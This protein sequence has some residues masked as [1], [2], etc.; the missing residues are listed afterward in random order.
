MLT[1]LVVAAVPGC[2]RKEKDEQIAADAK[3]LTADST[4][5]ATQA[6]VDEDWKFHLAWP[7]AG[8]KMMGESDVSRIGPDLVAGAIANNN[9]FGVIV[10]AQADQTIDQYVD[11]VLANRKIGSEAI[12]SRAAVQVAGVEGVRVVYTTQ[13]EQMPYRFAITAVAHEGHWYQLL[14]WSLTKNELLASYDQFVAAFSFL[15]GTPKGRTARAVVQ[16]DVDGPDWRLREGVFESATEG[17]RVRPSHDWRVAVGVELR[18]MNDSADVGLVHANPDVFVVML[19]DVTPEVAR[20]SFAESRRAEISASGGTWA[21]EPWTATLA[22]EPLAFRRLVGQP[23]EYLHAVRFDHTRA[24]QV[25]GWY[26]GNARDKAEPMLVH[27]F[28]G[29]E[30]MTDG[31]RESLRDELVAAVDPHEMVGEHERLREGVFRDYEHGIEW[32]KPEGLWRLAIGDEARASNPDA[33]LTGESRDVG[34]LFEL[35]AQGRGGRDADLVHEEAL[36]TYGLTKGKT[37]SIA[38]ADGTMVLSRAKKEHGGIVWSFSVGTALLQDRAMVLAVWGSESVA[39]AEHDRVFRGL[40]FADDLKA[41]RQQGTRLVDDRMGYA[42]EMPNGL[43]RQDVT[44]I[45]QTKIGTLSSWKGD[46]REV[47]LVSLCALGLG[48]DA[49]WLV[50]LMQQQMRT[51]MG[52]S[53]SATAQESEMLIAG[54]TAHRTTYKTL[55]TANDIIVFSHR[56]TVFALVTTGMS[57]SELEGIRSSFRLLDGTGR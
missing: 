20:E 5:D 45:D 4:Q 10:E 18:E 46:H 41:V 44:P 1:L 37:E 14:G 11:L 56:R 53:T 8:W 38:L 36:A 51:A 23:F 50:G 15:P 30:R 9:F 34:L 55:A 19:S 24:T 32:T 47:Q 43:T 49:D 2:N 54:K 52:T 7:G 29:I 42:V 28:A 31:E 39:Q 17:L 22:G 12:E 3:K 27:A 35:H 25:L 40:R 26:A 21:P 16:K 48:Q 6:V 13:I 33:V 57:D